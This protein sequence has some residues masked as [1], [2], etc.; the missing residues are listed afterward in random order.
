MLEVL[1][2]KFAIFN[3]SYVYPVSCQLACSNPTDCH[4]ALIL[5]KLPNIIVWS[6]AWRYVWRYIWRHVWGPC[7]EWLNRQFWR[8]GWRL[9]HEGCENE[10]IQVRFH[11]LVD[12][13]FSFWTNDKIIK[14][15]YNTNLSRFTERE[16]NV[17]LCFCCFFLHKYKYIYVVIWKNIK[18]QRWA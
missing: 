14:G 13:T 3:S 10:I 4:M 1:Y 2:A 17:R 16:N 6:A 18:L 9:C 7:H 5:T 15:N 12:T 8:Y 11:S